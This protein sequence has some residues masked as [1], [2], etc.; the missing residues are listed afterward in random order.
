LAVKIKD[1]IRK[2]IVA[3]KRNPH[4]IPLTM[5]I[6]CCVIYTFTLTAH[7]DTSMYV[8]NRE[9]ALYVFVI[10]LASMLIIFSFI[11]AYAKRNKHKNLMLGVVYFLALVQIV[12]DGIYLYI[13]YYETVLREHPVPINESSQFIA[14]S[15]FWTAFHLGAVAVSTLAVILLPV[16]RALLQ[17]IDTSVE[18]DEA[19]DIFDSEEKLI[20]DEE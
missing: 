15:R 1:K 9:I 13:I 3:V 11:N 18:D 4:Y 12:F 2:W 17:R 14:V 10:T 20:W 19:T 5:Y 8:S 7:S 6:I 16:Y